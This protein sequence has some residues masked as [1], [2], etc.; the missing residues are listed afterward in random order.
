[1]RACK[2]AY[3]AQED[4]AEVDERL[5]NVAVVGLGTVRLLGV[6]QLGKPVRQRVHWLVADG[7]HHHVE[8]KRRVGWDVALPAF[9]HSFI[10]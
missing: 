8:V 2:H 10:R 9:I 4:A 1:M 7:Q 6:G 5:G 3:L